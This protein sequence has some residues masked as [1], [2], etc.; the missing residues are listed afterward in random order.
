MNPLTVLATMR[1]APFRLKFAVIEL[2][3]YGELLDHG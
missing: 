2:W 1:G 3:G